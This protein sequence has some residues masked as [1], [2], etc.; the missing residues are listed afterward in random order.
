M[1]T[2]VLTCIPTYIRTYAHT[3]IHAFIC[4]YIHAYNGLTRERMT[5]GKPLIAKQVYTRPISTHPLSTPPLHTS[6]GHTLSLHTAPIHTHTLS[7]S[8]TR[9]GNWSTSDMG[10]PPPC[11]LF[12]DHLHFFNRWLRTSWPRW[13]RRSAST[14]PS[15]TSAL[16][17]TV[18]G[19]LTRPPPPWPRYYRPVYIRIFFHQ[20]LL[21]VLRS[22]KSINRRV[23]A[24]LTLLLRLFH[25]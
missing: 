5:F 23:G 10:Q 1:H 4:T 6:P 19:A 15:S 8:I 22:T 14:A 16:P 2:Y 17:C 3:H 21:D 12:T 24:A 18:R 9:P 7:Q 20:L 25:K 11:A 13:R